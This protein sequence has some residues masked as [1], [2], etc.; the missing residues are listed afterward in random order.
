MGGRVYES[1]QELKIKIS[2]RGT[3]A[4]AHIRKPCR[5]VG[6]GWAAVGSDD[7]DE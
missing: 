5:R 4:R 7:D 1:M 6:G 2:L 3:R